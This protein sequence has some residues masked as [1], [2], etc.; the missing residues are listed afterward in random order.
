LKTALLSISQP[1]ILLGMSDE[2]RAAQ[3]GNA[4][5]ECQAAK[6]ELAHIQRKL[7]AVFTAYSSLGACLNTHD[8]PSV[9]NGKLELGESWRNHNFNP[10]N[11][12]SK[13]DLILVL[14][15]HKK[16]NIRLD[17]ARQEMADLGITSLG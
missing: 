7:T 13:A 11:L 4:A 1:L 8:L 6:I 17:K 9:R 5:S 2:E 12:L 10:D 15:E 16:A 3:I 14:E